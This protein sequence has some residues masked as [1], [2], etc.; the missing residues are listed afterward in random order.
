[1]KKIKLENEDKYKPHESR[2]I[3]FYSPMT[4]ECQTQYVGCNKN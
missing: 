1:M 2:E 3:L 4:P